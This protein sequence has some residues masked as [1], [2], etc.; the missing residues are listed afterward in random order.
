MEKR[1]DLW[2]VRSL[3]LFLWMMP[4]IL[5]YLKAHSC[6]ISQQYTMKTYFVRT[7]GTILLVQESWS[8]GYI[9]TLKRPIETNGFLGDIGKYGVREMKTHPNLHIQNEFKRTK[10]RKKNIINNMIHII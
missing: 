3:H 10:G 9:F 6:I 2:S 5:L 4:F 8:N 1:I 7:D